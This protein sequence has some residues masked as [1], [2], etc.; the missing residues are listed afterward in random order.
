LGPAQEHSTCFEGVSIVHDD[1]FRFEA[2]LVTGKDS[3][4]VYLF[5]HIAGPKIRCQLDAVGTG[6]NTEGNPTFTYSG[7][8]T[9]RGK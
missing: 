3:G 4:R 1:Q 7:Q 5:D 8:C 2:D 6:V 9:F